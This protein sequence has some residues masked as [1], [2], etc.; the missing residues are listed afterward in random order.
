M[1]RDIAKVDGVEVERWTD[2]LIFLFRLFFEKGSDVS[3]VLDESGGN[4]NAY[5][6]ATSIRLYGPIRLESRLHEVT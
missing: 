3:L 4:V 5:H 1:K 2:T 6:K